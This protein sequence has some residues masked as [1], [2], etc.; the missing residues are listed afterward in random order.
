MAI[1]Q[2]R[3]DNRLVHGQI[4]SAWVP[5][6][7]ADALVVLDDEA[8]GNE[9]LQSAMEIAIPPGVSFSV[10]SVDQAAK[11]L[12]RLPGSAK[13]IVLV[14]GVDDAAR[15]APG[16]GG[17]S[18]WTLGNVHFAAGRLPVSQAVF[19]SR[20][21]L[22]TLERLERSGLQVELKTLPRDASVPLSEVRARAEASARS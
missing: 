1:V 15:I 22:A 20:D 13:A 3:I 4:L 2:A 12:G 21:E 16:T 7:R 9:L 5:A 14:R 10:A 17:L 18:R 11:A 8:A 6:L 19:L